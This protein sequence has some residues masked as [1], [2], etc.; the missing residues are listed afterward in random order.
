MTRIHLSMTTPDLAATTAFYTQLFGEP[1][2]VRPGYV[3]FA[4]A[5]APIL[6]SLMEGEASV[7][8]LGVRMDDVKATKA[9]WQRLTS[10]GLSPTTEQDVNCCFAVQNKAWVSDPDGRDWE[11]YTVTDDNP[12]QADANPTACCA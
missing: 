2:K 6:L 8:H 5:E 12:V 9:A 1:D 11:L 7:H 10:A 4:P 3:R